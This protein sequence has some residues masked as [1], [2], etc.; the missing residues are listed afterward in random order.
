MVN[1]LN[2]MQMLWGSKGE[3]VYSSVKFYDRN[4]DIESKQK[5]NVC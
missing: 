1:V 4:I 2:W 3:H 5:N